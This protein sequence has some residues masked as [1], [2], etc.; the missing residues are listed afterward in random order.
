MFND[1]NKGYS[2]FKI[3][4]IRAVFY[5][6]LIGSGFI[7]IYKSI[8]K[9]GIWTLFCIMTGL[10]IISYNSVFRKQE[11]GSLGRGIVGIVIIFIIY[12]SY[13]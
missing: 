6:I 4:L 9:S 2:I 5:G 10:L 7:L 11:N 3:S 8:T 13:L 12:F 1:D